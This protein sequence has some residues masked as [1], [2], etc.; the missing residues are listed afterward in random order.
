MF[1]K[2]LA[3]R[4]HGGS[5]LIAIP[6]WFVKEFQLEKGS[7]LNMSYE[8]RKLVIDLDSAAPARPRKNHAP[9]EITA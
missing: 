2:D 1:S 4:E 5:I 3:L 8:D 7:R 9:R 6:A